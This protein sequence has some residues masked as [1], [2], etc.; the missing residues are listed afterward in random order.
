MK[1]TGLVLFAGWLAA[2]AVNYGIYNE[3][4]DPAFIS[5]FWDGIVFMLLMLGVYH[6]I[7]KSF[8]YKPSTASIQL[9]AG[10]ALSLTAALLLL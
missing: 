6:L 1:W 9:A 8:M 4:T 7:W 2:M 3:S 10:G 5:P